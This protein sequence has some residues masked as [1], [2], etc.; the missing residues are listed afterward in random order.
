M[1]VLAQ[2]GGQ[3]CVGVAVPVAMHGLRALFINVLRTRT[4][5]WS[6]VV[7]IRVLEFDRDSDAKD[8]F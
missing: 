2:T 3:G 5:C 8:A 4:A 6:R 1:D 7:I